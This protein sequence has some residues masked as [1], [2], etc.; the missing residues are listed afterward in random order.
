[1]M[2]VGAQSYET[3][4]GDRQVGMGWGGKGT[5]VFEIISLYFYVLFF[6]NVYLY[7]F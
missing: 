5:S 6:L 2:Y 4:C 3:C 7:I 1:M